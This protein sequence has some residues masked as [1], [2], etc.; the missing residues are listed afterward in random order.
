MADGGS[1]WNFQAE[2]ELGNNN[3]GFSVIYHILNLEIL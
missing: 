2:I 3:S 1:K